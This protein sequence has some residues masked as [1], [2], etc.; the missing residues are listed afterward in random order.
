MFL[1]GSERSDSLEYVPESCVEVET[2][3]RPNVGEEMSRAK[4][5]PKLCLPFLIHK[6]VYQVV[7]RLSPEFWLDFWP[8]QVK[9]LKA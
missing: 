5:T 9:Q 6:E 4:Q 7:K 3:P 8:C 2:P 1:T